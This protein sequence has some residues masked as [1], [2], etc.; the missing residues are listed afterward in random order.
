MLSSVA[1]LTAQFK[2]NKEQTEASLSIWNQ[3]LTSI[4]S[5]VRTRLDVIDQNTF[6]T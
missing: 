4:Y 5:I 1:K 2:Q 3:Q 6:G